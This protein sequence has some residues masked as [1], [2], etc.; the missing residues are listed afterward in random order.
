MTLVKS[1]TLEYPVIE[2]LPSKIYESQLRVLKN[3]KQVE[4]KVFER[5]RNEPMPHA[6]TIR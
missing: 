5:L 6:K 3:V 1:N 2:C 4:K